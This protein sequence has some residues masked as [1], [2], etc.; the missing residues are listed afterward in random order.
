VPG[1]GLDAAGVLDERASKNRGRRGVG[2]RCL[3]VPTLVVKAQSMDASTGSSAGSAEALLVKCGRCGATNRVD[4]ARS[5]DARCGRCKSPLAPAA[6]GHPTEVTDASF[7]AEVEASPLPVLVDFWAPWCAPCRMV[8]P[9]LEQIAAE[10]AGRLRVVKVNVDENPR[11]ASRFSI[12]SIPTMAV[13]RGG[14]LVDQIRGAA[15]KQAIE[16]RLD[17]I[18]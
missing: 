7:A 11:L 10:R 8:A 2:G 15:P 9:I 4:R 12:Q 13:F 3:T 5:G 14:A 1:D 18:L 16:A 17:R 6:S